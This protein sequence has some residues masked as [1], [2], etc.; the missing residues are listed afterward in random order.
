MG[1]RSG[2]MLC[3]QFDERRLE[4]WGF[5]VLVQPKIN[6]VRCRTKIDK[7]TALTLRSSEDNEIVSVPHI[8]T[9]VKHLFSAV[10][11]LLDGELYV[12]NTPLGD[13]T[14]ITSRV[15]NLHPNHDV[16]EYH[17]FDIIDSRA[18]MSQLAMV[19]LSMQKAI[20]KYK[21]RHLKVVPTLVV[22]GIDE[23]MGC[24]ERWVSEGYEGI[25]IRK[26]DG[27]YVE[28]RSTEIMKSKKRRLTP[29]VVLRA[30]EEE[31]IHGY[32][33]G[34]LG[35]VECVLDDGT[36]FKVGTGF[37]AQEREDWWPTE[38]LGKTIVVEYQEL[39]AA[40]VPYAPSFK[41][42]IDE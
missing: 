21:L 12:H 35:A 42:V 8:L 24:K 40:G 7:V 11:A 26:Y 32:K 4:R 3:Y 13:I 6:G 36:I 28:K 29:A 41:G 30:I 22:T 27:K 19:M 38:L 18:D 23:I 33:K 31:S 2:V 17:I 10:P 25:I 34:T 14:S 39:T 37:T 1:K 20:E 5:P 15:V 16:I 9:E